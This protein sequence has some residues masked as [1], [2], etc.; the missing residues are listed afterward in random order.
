MRA[1]PCGAAGAASRF[2]NNRKLVMKD[3]VTEPRNEPEIMRVKARS[4][5]ASCNETAQKPY[6]KK[7]YMALELARTGPRSTWP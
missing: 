6:G 1:Q 5:A 4:Y 7:I 2:A 3:P